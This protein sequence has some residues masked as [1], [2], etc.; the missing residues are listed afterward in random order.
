MSISILTATRACLVLIACYVA[1]L[2]GG[3]GQKDGWLIEA[4][5]R[6]AETEFAGV[7]A[8]GELVRAGQPAAAYDM[9]AHRAAFDAVIGRPK[10]T[11]YYAWPYPPHYLGVAW[12]LA[13][14]PYVAAALA[15]IAATLALQAWAAVRIIGNRDAALWVIAS[16]ATFINATVAHTGFLVAG[17]FGLGLATLPTSPVAAGVAFGLL[18]FKPQLGLLLPLALAAGGHWRAMA[19]AAV[20]VVLTGLLSLLAFGIEPWL[21]FLPQLD[22]VAGIF[23][24]GKVNMLMMITFYGFARSL[25]AGHGAA[26][27]VQAAATI[28]LAVAV[29]RL[30]RSDAPYELKAAGLTVA[31]LLATPYL[32]PY[33]LTLLTVALLFLVRLSGPALLDQTEILTV[34]AGGLC[35]LLFGVLPFQA[36]LV[37]TL[38]TG[39]L[40]VRRWRQL[41]IARRDRA[42]GWSR[43]PRAVLAGAI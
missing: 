24:S 3:Y 37:A 26:T 9:A 42:I 18:A 31:S 15:L 25:G 34:L 6:P 40:V 30:W 1:V 23:N 33:D 29:F 4:D 13:L 41:E 17:L 32:F 2:A 28:T 11:Y 12:L 36:G 14:L 19:V 39:A 38:M 35:L 20:T 8:T 27:I 22:R 16:P 43:P 7:R 10:T 5:G 21:A